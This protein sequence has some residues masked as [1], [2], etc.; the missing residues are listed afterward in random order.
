M[1]CQE[2]KLALNSK[3]VSYLRFDWYY[4]KL[5]KCTQSIALCKYTVKGLLEYTLG[6]VD[7]IWGFEKYNFQS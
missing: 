7:D 3:D 6:R 1:S 4:S 5:S 2:L